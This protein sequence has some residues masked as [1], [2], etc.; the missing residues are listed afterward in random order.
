MCW[1]IWLTWWLCCHSL[2]SQ[3]VAM[4]LEGW[5]SSEAYLLL[6]WRPNFG[7]Y[8][9]KFTT[10]SNFSS[11]GS[12]TTFYP[13]RT[14]HTQSYTQQS[15]HV[16]KIRINIFKGKWTGSG[17][18]GQVCGIVEKHWKEDWQK[19]VQAI[20]YRNIFSV[21]EWNQRWTHYSESVFTR[22]GGTEET[23]HNCQPFKS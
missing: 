2:S 13:L 21:S 19:E 14:H 6:M 9:L 7:S 20:E 16:H 4:G 10:I 3:E 11:R 17:D 1:S 18:F 8:N 5:L 12:S 23:S 22:K 15:M